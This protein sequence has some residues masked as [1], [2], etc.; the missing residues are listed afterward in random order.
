MKIAFRS[1]LS[2]LEKEAI[3]TTTIRLRNE[4]FRVKSEKRF[5]DLIFDLYAEKGSDKRI[6]EFKIKKKIHSSSTLERDQYMRL[7]RAANM[8]GARLLFI[9]IDPPKGGALVSIDDLEE[10][11]LLDIYE[12]KESYI[13]LFNDPTIQNVFDIE[14]EFVSIFPSNVL[15]RGKALA[16]IESFVDGIDREKFSKNPSLSS[17]KNDYCPFYFEI[18]MDESLTIIESEY[19]FEIDGHK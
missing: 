10:R 4:G 16:D 3:R 19:S 8:L 7:Q 1:V 5:E 14:I 17:L 9:Y 15:V 13:S 18:R 6:Y 2:A 11:M 12:K